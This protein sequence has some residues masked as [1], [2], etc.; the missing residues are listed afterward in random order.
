MITFE[1]DS[2][3]GKPSIGSR[4]SVEVAIVSDRNTGILTSILGTY[5]DVRQHP[6]TT[7]GSFEL[8]FSFAI[9]LSTILTIKL[10]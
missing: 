5:D 10:Y 2:W 9:I 8:S 1:S 3:V 4:R 6:S 7:D